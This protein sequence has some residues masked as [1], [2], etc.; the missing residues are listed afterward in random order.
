MKMDVVPGRTN[1]FQV[2]PTE[3]GT[4][5]GKCTELCGTYHSRMLFNVLVTK[6]RKGYYE[7]WRADS[8]KSYVV[9]SSRPQAVLAGINVQ[10]RS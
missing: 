10:A 6:T 7:V 5:K 2:T 4:F 1:S 9:T 3:V 8:L